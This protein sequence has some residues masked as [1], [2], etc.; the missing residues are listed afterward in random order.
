MK[1][2]WL[3]DIH[4]NFLEHDQIDAFLEKVSA[5]AADCFLVSGDTGE[6]PSITGYL[7][8]M[9]SVLK[10]PIYFV[11]GN[12]DYYGG[13]IKTVRSKVVDLM[14]KSDKL[15]WL[16]NIDFIS[17]TKDTALIGHDSWADGRLGD[18]RG[19]S[20]ELNDF[21]FISELKL[22]DRTE[23]LKA[24]QGLADEAAEHFKRT[25][26]QALKAHRHII[27]VTHVP[28]FKEACWYEGK[29]SGDDWLPFF[30]CKAVGD[31]LKDVMEQN[32]SSEMT[33]FC[34]HTH[35]FGECQILQNLK[36]ITGG[37]EYG[38]PQIQKLIEIL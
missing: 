8:R 31:V 20:V 5:E 27:V 6:A 30:S 32:P 4:L 16:N 36:V 25:L 35:G 13:S 10:R 21:R 14:Q 9:I 17:L 23:R 22:W 15:I 24:M 2:A 26:T 11:L 3:T 19:S 34:G 18:F 1:A 38:A 7:Q 37:A 29:P 28:P 12:H 33:V